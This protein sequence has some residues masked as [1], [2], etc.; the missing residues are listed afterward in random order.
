M[1]ERVRLA[2]AAAVFIAGIGVSGAASANTATA[3]SC[4]TV[5][6]SMVKAALG[7][8]PGTP[9]SSTSSNSFF[10]YKATNLSCTYSTTINVTYSTPA[11][12]GDYN[13]ALSTLKNVAGAKLVSGIG[14]GAFSGTGSNAVCS[15]KCV[16]VKTQNL[17]VLVTGKTFFEIS[18]S[19]ATT[20]QEE[21]LAKKMVPLV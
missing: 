5:S 19:K 20:A 16:S 11:T 2:V 13:K 4:S 3:P 17:W 12:V 7:G 14:N 6:P 9:G 15:P 21:A 1:S 18:G 10:G 8:S